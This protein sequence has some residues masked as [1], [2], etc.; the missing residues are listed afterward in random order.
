MIGGIAKKVAG[1][2]LSKAGGAG[3]S[4][5]KKGGGLQKILKKLQEKLQEAKSPQEAQALKDRVLQKLQE[6][7][8][9]TPQLQQAIQTMP[10]PVG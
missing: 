8:K 7:G 10:S 2:L 6:G 1:G 5:K 3:K 4:G 9:L